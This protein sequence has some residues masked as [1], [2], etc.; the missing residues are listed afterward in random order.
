MSAPNTI[1]INGTIYNKCHVSDGLWQDCLTPCSL[2]NE[3]VQKE[4]NKRGSTFC[5]TDGEQVCYVNLA[6]IYGED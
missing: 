1:E 4:C 6:A 3:S 2:C 5:F